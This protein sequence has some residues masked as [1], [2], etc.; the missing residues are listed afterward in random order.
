MKVSKKVFPSIGCLIYRLG[1]LI[2][3]IKYYLFNSFITN[4]P[5]YKIRNFYLGKIIGIKIGK[6]TAIHMGCFFAGRN[7]EI[8][9]NN[10]IGRKCYFDGRTG[11]ILIK[12]N[13]S[14]SPESY[15]LT[16]THI[17]DSPVF[18]HTYK[19]ITINKFV[20][21]GVRALVLPGVTIGE[22]AVLGA[23]SVATKDIKEFTVWAGIPAVFISN[24]NNEL[25]YELN[26]FPYFN[27]D[28]N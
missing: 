21:I 1:R 13:V 2:L 24:R 15:F 18:E 28:I 10:V 8:G 12:D 7:I 6:N 3:G 9:N 17:K 27:S 4:I 16:D 23:G 19:N 5:S 22:G 11:K 26:Y 20:W 14:I 25:N